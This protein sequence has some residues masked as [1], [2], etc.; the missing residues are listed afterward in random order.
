M[1]K[2]L[3]EIFRENR[4]LLI[5]LPTIAAN[6]LQDWADRKHSARVL[7]IAVLHTFQGRLNFYPHVHLVVSSVGLDR[8]GK[9]LVWDV[10]WDFYYVQQALMKKWRHAVV[11]YLLAALDHGLISSARPKHELRALFEEHRGRWWKAGV[12]ECTSVRAL[13]KYMSRYLRRPPIAQRR[14]LFYDGERVRFWYKDTKSK[15]RL[16]EECS[17]D[18]F[19]RRW[20]DHVPDRYRHG[21]HY[22]GLLAPRCKGRGYEA[23][24]VLLGQK[25]RP[26]PRR[27]RWRKLIWLTFGRDPLLASNGEVMQKIGWKAPERPK[28][29]TGQILRR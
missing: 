19:I 15:Q 22:F 18:E 9:R 12:R 28:A 17:A 14:L 6:V 5:G 7:I 21:V 2:D 26:R 13:V 23:F 16:V 8:S 27:T 3:W 4:Q 24:R 25:R 1:H 11:D 10:R 29:T 20:S